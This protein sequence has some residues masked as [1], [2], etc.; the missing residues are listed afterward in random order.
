MSLHKLFPSD[1]FDILFPGALIFICV[2][3]SSL[4]PNVLGIS[5]TNNEVPLMF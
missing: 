5:A 4:I 1:F 3:T 2:F